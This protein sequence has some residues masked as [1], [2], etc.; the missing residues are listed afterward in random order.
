MEWLF[1]PF[2][3]ETGEKAKRRRFR[4]VPVRALIPN[5]ITL[6]ALCMGL[7]AIRMAMEQRFEWAVAAIVI[8]AVLDSLDGRVARLLRSTSRFGAELDSLADFVNFG[9]APAILLYS[10]SL[11]ALKSAGWIALLCFTLCCALRL[12]RFNV[13]LESPKPAW[14]ANYFTG[15]P[16]PAG[17]I[18]ALLPVF[19]TYLEVLDTRGLAL[20]ILI[21]TG[22][23]AFLLISRIPTFSGK[24]MGQRV[25]RDMVLPLFVLFVLVVAC[26][27]AFPWLTLTVGTVAYLVSIP[28]SLTRYQQLERRFRARQ[29]KASGGTEKDG[30]SAVASP[31]GDD[32]ET[33][34][35]KLH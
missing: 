18:T 2:D 23:L 34:P 22:L 6:L 24:A 30:F 9:V 31:D 7:T 32:D 17:A 26:L 4:P 11:S 19:L 33:R 14:Q 29:E 25:R 5:M 3:P 12:A 13:A 20:P 16:A 8:A 21:Y 15:M 28:V 35:E 27:V 1:P 10:W